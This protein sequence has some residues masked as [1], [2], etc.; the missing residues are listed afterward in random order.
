M[1][2]L[3]PTSLAGR[4][5]FALLFGLVL[6]QVAGLTIHALDRMDLQR[7]QQARDVTGRAF[8]LWRNLL[9]TPPDRRGAV[10]A[11]FDLPPGLRA[12]VDD[13]PV[14]NRAFPPPP[15]PLDRMFRVEALM[16]GPPRFRPRDVIVSGAPGRPGAML[17]SARFLDG[18]W[19]NLRVELPPPRP[20]HSETFL[21]AFLGMTL[22]AA[23]LTL[24]AVR[25]LTRPVRA[26]ADAADRLGRD[27][28]AP[29]LPE[30]GP[31]EVATAP[32]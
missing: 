9:V 2:R 13:E 19:L 17:L 27:V 12:S 28:N 1:R 11:D 7:F 23:A 10:L 16:G 26:L 6:V 3:L 32:D 14:A 20:W 25:R 4:T 5:A 30:A 24:W 22:A 15:P 21:I 18:A 31:A 29:P 8:A